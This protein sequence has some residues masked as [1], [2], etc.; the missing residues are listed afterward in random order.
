MSIYLI[1]HGETIEGLNKILLGHCNGMLTPK[2][3]KQAK[4]VS[5]K[6]IGIE[7]IITSDLY[8]ALYFTQLI[9]QMID[10]SYKTDFRLRERNYGI[11]NREP[12]NKLIL[13]YRSFDFEEAPPNGEKKVD[14][15]DRVDSF[16]QS[17]I[18]LDNIAVVSHA[19][20]IMRLMDNL[21]LRKYVPKFGEVI[22]IC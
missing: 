5:E 11:Y 8:R 17:I 9:Q 18:N 20:V 19:G 1:R 16:Y 22:K 12:I 13:D 21:R 15:Y 14:F 6:I 7:Q 3:I 4:E 2:G 10:V